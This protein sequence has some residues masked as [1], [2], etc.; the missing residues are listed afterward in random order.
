MLL[1]ALLKA[2]G[3]ARDCYGGDRL[4]CKYVIGIGA[5]VERVPKRNMAKFEEFC[6]YEEYGLGE[7]DDGGVIDLRRAIDLN[8]DYEASNSNTRHD[9][10]YEDTPAQ[11]DAHN[12]FLAREMWKGYK[13]WLKLCPDKLERFNQFVVRSSLIYRFQSACYQFLT[14]MLMKGFVAP[15]LHTSAKKGEGRPGKKHKG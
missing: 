8:E 1:N 6:N 10:W 9:G 12:G 5:V 2:V 13:D 7:Y 11:R 3:I 4:N 14:L 15:P